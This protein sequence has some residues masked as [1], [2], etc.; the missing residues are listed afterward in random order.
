[1]N[2]FVKFVVHHP[3]IVIAIVLAATCGF[4]VI[5]VRRGI[6]FNG[7]P[8]TL[9][10]KD[11]A[12]DFFHETRK[13]FGDD[14][15][16]IVALTTEDALAPAF[17]DKLDR[18]TK[19]LAVVDGVDDVLSLTTLQAIRRRDDGV[20]IERLVPLDRRSPEQ[21]RALKDEITRDPL[22]ARQFISTDGR[23][24]A[25]NVFLKLLDEAEARKV[26]EEVER[27]AKAENDGDELFLA[28]VPV[29]DAHGVRHT[30]RDMMVLSPL[31][32]VVCFLIFLAAFRR[33]WCAMLP[34]AAL[35]I[36]LMWTIGLMAWFDR[37]ITLAT[38]SLPTTLMAVGGSYLFHVLNKHR[39]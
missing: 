34:M 37:P 32:A 39:L 2:Q 5:L 17:I 20:V 1:M 15:V 14:R 26:A 7:S 23:T 11:A 36:G 4:G 12:L 24:A 28:G 29:M 30:V 18:L 16:I 9:A 21:L 31:A 8:E 13:T 35:V 38:L 22:Y 3:K 6:P 19:R 27:V 10:R 25:V 33:F